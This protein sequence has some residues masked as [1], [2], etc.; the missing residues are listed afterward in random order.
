MR[1]CKTSLSTK[2]RPNTRDVCARAH[3]KL[4]LFPWSFLPRVILPSH[5]MQVFLS[6]AVL[7]VPRLLHTCNAPLRSSRD[8]L[9]SAPTHVMCTCLRFSQ[10]L[11]PRCDICMNS[12]FPYMRCNLFVAR[13]F[14]VPRLMYTCNA[15]LQSSRD[16]LSS[17]QTFHNPF[18]SV[19]TS[20]CSTLFSPLGHF[21]VELFCCLLACCLLAACLLLACCLLAACVLAACCLLAACL[22]LA[23]SRNSRMFYLK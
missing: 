20:A 9:S 17:A 1:R 6:P 15:P 4:N 12:L 8:V 21:F 13:C 2:Q 3:S 19:V 16:V 10:S 7:C 5:C 11:F 22:L 23:L 18:F 14:C